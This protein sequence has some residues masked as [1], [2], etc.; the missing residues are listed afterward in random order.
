VLN[1]GVEFGQA[2]IAALALPIL[3]K[4]R[5]VP[6][7]RYVEITSTIIALAGAWWLIQRVIL[8]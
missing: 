3:Y 8:A 7:T 2:V 4:L 5:Q 1:L 6:R